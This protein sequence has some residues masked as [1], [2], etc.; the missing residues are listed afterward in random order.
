GIGA[1]A[2]PSSSGKRLRRAVDRSDI[3]L[4]GWGSWLPRRIERCTERL[5]GCLQ[6]RDLLLLLG[7]DEAAQGQ[8][9]GHLGQGGQSFGDHVSLLERW[10]QDFRIVA[11][12][13]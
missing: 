12:G 11:A 6:G 9:A 13:L 10:R 8:S 4:I 3:V 7:R 2:P 1:V 5:R